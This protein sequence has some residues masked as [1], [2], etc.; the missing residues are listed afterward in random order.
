MAKNIIPHEHKISPHDR[1]GL[2]GHLGKVIWM[3]GLSGSGKS[4]IAG[5]LDEKLFEDKRHCFILDGDNVRSGL[6]TDLGFSIEDRNENL[7]RIAHVANLMADAGLIVICAFISPLKK[8]R[9]LIK[10]IVGKH[11]YILV[12][13]DCDLE[14]C[15]ERD[16]KGLYAKARKGIIPE[17]TGISSPY[18]NPESPDVYINTSKQSKAACLKEILANIAPQINL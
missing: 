13:V 7:R 15:E 14:V 11:R 8:E 17:F 4:T 5:L 18:E 9:N 6:N 16:P 1:E 12:H 3:T 2:N 10:E